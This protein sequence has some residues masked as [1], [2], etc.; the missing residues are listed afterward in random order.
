MYDGET[1]RPAAVRGRRPTGYQGQANQGARHPR[2][3]NS[4]GV[5]I[6]EAVTKSSE[7]SVSMAGQGADARHGGLWPMR[8]TMVRLQSV[9]DV[10]GD[11]GD[12]ASVNRPAPHAKRRTEPGGSGTKA[13]PAPARFPRPWLWAIAVLVIGLGV[14]LGIDSYNGRDVGVAPA[15][16][17]TIR[18]DATGTGEPAVPRTDLHDARLPA[19]SGPHVG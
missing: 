3:W 1:P 9:V 13:G 11:I 14:A 16:S 4:E 5:A 17:G 15:K 19:R 18:R 8:E 12:H 2:Q 7:T 6:G 10:T